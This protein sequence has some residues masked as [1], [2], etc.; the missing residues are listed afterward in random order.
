MGALCGACPGSRRM[1]CGTGMRS[2][3]GVAGVTP[4]DASH[5]LGRVDAWDTE[6]ARKALAL[7]GRR[8]T[9][10]GEKLAQDPAGMAQI[11]VDQLTH[12]TGL[13]LL[14]AG[15]A[16]ESAE[17]GLSPEALARH[18]LMQAG[19][20]GHRGIVRV[21]TGLNLPVIGLG[22]SAPS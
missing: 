10:A 2:C 19:L 6:A 21:E 5:V 9:G 3:W 1:V 4:S 20:T 14:E 12:Q 13:A 22:A 8:R 7:F 18:A 15:F 16:Q 11:I 17:F